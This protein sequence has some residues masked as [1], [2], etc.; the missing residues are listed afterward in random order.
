MNMINTTARADFAKAARAQLLYAGL[1]DL[2]QFAAE[3]NRLRDA[4][5][6]LES[7]GDDK[8]SKRAERLGRQ[9]DAFEPSVTMI[10]QIKSGKT[11]L[12]NALIGCPDLLPADVNPWTSVVTSLHLHPET[13]GFRQS[14]SFQ[15]FDEDEWDRL[16][17]GGGRIGE[18]AS[19]AGADDELEKIKRQVAQMREKSRSRLGRKFEV[20]LGQ[21]RDY[22]YFDKDLIERYVCLGDD[23]EAHE[24]AL[25]KGQGRFA[26]ITKSADLNMERLALPIRLCLRDTP[27]VND[28]FMM[29]EQITIRSIRDSRLCVVVLSAH[30]ALSSTDLALIRLISHVKT[31]DVV[32]F[33]NRIDELSDPSAQIPQIAGSV[34]ATLER[35]K[36]PAGAQLVFGSA[37]WA[38]RALEGDITKLPKSSLAAL[39]NWS[40]GPH[41]AGPDGDR[42]DPVAQ[43]WALSGLPALQASLSER[44]AQGVG[45]ANSKRIAA[46][47]LNLAGALVASDRLV[48]ASGAGGGGTQL[49]GPAAQRRMAEISTSEATALRAEFDSILAVFSERLD[50]VQSSFL[51]R[52]IASLVLHLERHGDAMPWT[53]D[54]AG[55]RVL[56]ASSHQVVARKSQQAFDTAARRTAARMVELY[57]AAF[58][59]GPEHIRIT[60]PA[61][62]AVPPPVTLARTIA[63]D[64]S[65]TWWKRWWFQK[66]GYEAYA[67]RFHDLIRSETNAMVD[68][69]RHDL[70]VGLRD[71]AIA[72]FDAFVSEQNTVFNALVDKR[73]RGALS[74]ETLGARG[75]PGDQAAQLEAVVSEFEGFLTEAGDD[76]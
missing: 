67:A 28:T 73:Q 64:L 70:A 51:E 4:L 68:E 60:L 22:G 19:R 63:L 27:G 20:L 66:R 76:V 2:R 36:G 31:R 23:L 9:L 47:A 40:E 50:R 14:A 61:A 43:A 7:L 59:L 8:I 33:V 49:E 74:P 42:P 44:I 38:C 55:L 58:G 12:V 45:A 13:E 39:R 65:S 26:D 71:A 57:N 24:Q 32:I 37:L 34:R 72:A 21:K 52:A 41:G 25:S 15:F 18:L 29:R 11:S 1:E 56:L 30:Q 5:R 16:V 48:A 53:Y 46:S 3:S 54:P 35:H 69:L 62:P 6:T 17:S 75:G 10:G